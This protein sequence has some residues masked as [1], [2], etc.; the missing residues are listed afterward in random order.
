M[1][2][3]IN[4]LTN[5]LQSSAEG[6]I[7]PDSIQ[8]DAVGGLGIFIGMLNDSEWITWLTAASVLIFNI[9]KIIS[10]VKKQLKTNSK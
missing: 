8:V 6:L 5:I 2:I 1:Q 10:Q 9:L 3:P 4:T 7:N